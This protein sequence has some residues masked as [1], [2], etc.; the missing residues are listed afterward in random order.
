MNPLLNA[1]DLAQLRDAAGAEL[2]E[3]NRA[4]AAAER[5]RNYAYARWSLLE[6]ITRKVEE[7]NAQTVLTVRPCGCPREDQP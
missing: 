7:L 5:R 1:T 2:E 4:A 6:D 3:A